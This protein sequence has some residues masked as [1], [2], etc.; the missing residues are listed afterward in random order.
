MMI[1]MRATMRANM[2]MRRFSSCRKISMTFEGNTRGIAATPEERM[3]RIFGGRLKGEPPKSTS[4]ILT[5][6][7]KL[8]AGVEVPEKPGQPDNCCMSGCVNCVW[9]L[10]NDDVRYWKQKRN[11]AALK[12][13]DSTEVWPSNW[14]PPLDKL[15]MKNIPPTLHGKKMKLEEDLAKQHQTVANLFPKRTNP[16][17]K[18][19]QQAKQRNLAKKIHTPVE[20]NDGWDDIPVYIKAFAEF[21]RQRKLKKNKIP[22]QTSH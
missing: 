12:I 22:P 19:V 3:Q 15:E 4:R 13:R 16:L 20:E 9:E 11:E 6:G 2:T 14:D 5:G 21:E 10:Y 1:T 18:S 17:P 7:S 8:I